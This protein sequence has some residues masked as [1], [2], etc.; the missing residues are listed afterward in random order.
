LATKI[1]SIRSNKGGDFDEKLEKCLND[2]T[3]KGYKFLDVK[4]S[5][6]GIQTSNGPMVN[7]SALVVYDNLR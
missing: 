1:M 5:T 6:T 2:I 7:Y 3:E 4:Y